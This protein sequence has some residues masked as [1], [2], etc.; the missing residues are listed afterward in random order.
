MNNKGSLASILSSLS[1]EVW[2]PQSDRIMGD[3]LL[4]SNNI[5]QTVT[6]FFAYFLYSTFILIKLRHAVVKVLQIAETESIA[7]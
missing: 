1:I 7:L 4:N 2:T 6:E 5:F 3:I